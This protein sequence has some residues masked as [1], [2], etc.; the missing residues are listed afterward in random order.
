ASC[1]P[2]S[3]A[4]PQ[5]WLVPV[6]GGRPAAMTPRRG[7]SSR[8]LGDLDAWSLSS[9][10]YLQAAGPCGVL[11][12]FKQARNGS[13]TLVKVPHTNGDN[14]VLTALGSRLLIRAPTSCTGSNSLLWFNPGTG[15]EQW[16]IHAPANEV[17][18]AAAIPFYSRQDGS[19]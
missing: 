6:S 17:G 7:A 16:L 4:A 2:P 8:D 14:D 19:L 3:T 12:I 1:A 18:V 13:I 5:L 11:Q 15:A 9:G 10:L